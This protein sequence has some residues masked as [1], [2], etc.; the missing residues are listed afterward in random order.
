MCCP[1]GSE[2]FAA[3][4]SYP[5]NFDTSPLNPPSSLANEEVSSL[6]S[7]MLL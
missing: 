2:A 6:L 1:Q 3:A 5:S 7:C 4:T